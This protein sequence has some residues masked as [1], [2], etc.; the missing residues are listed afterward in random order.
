MGLSSPWRQCAVSRLGTAFI[1]LTA[2]AGP[3]PLG[4]GEADRPREL[5]RPAAATAPTNFWSSKAPAPTT[6]YLSSAGVINNSIYVVGGYS[7]G[8]VSGAMAAYS[9]GTNSWTSKA[10]M[11]EDLVFLN[12]TGVINGV[13]YVAG[14]ARYEYPVITHGTHSTPITPRPIPGRPRPRCPRRPLAEPRG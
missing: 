5:P 9:P 3:E 13:M 14:G 2:C 1:L 11:P 12:G 10:A 4:P 6:R 8:L 7:D